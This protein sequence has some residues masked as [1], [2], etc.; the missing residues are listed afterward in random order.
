MSESK[1][2]CTKTEVGKGIWK[3]DGNKFIF[4]QENDKTTFEGKIINNFLE[5]EVESASSNT[6]STPA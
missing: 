2:G 3:A 6:E 1:N 4:T 5:I